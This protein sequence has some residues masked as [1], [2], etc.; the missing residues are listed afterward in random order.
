MP[1]CLMMWDWQVFSAEP[2]PSCW[3]NL[4]FLSPIFAFSTFHGLVVWD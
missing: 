3:H 1:L 4:C 2:M